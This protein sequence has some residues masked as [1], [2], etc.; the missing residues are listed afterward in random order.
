ME[1]K[2]EQYLSPLSTRYASKEMQFLFSDQHKFSTWRQLWIWLAEAE[3]ASVYILKQFKH[4]L[5][6]K[7]IHICSHWAWT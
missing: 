6:L 3:Q 4:L 2:H 5:K 1:N 7:N